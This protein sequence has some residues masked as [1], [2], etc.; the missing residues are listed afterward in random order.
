MRN[1]TWVGSTMASSPINCR[2][3]ASSVYLTAL[4]HASTSARSKDIKSCAFQPC[5]AKKPCT[6][7]T[8]IRTSAKSQPRESLKVAGRTEAAEMPD[9]QSILHDLEKSVHSGQF[10]NL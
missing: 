5:S 10:E 4:L 8:A 7:C 2:R 1:S 9:M 6:A 3:P